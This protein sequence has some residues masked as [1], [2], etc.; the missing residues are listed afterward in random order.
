MF[1]GAAIP[2]CILVMRKCRKQKEDILFIDASQQFEKVKTTNVMRAE[3]IAKIVEVYKARVA[4]EKFS[5]LVSINEIKE[6]GWSLN[7]PKYVVRFEAEVEIDLNDLSTKLVMLDREAAEVDKKI[8][9]FCEELGI[10]PPFT[11]DNKS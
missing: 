4:E 9:M 2:T 6:N 10:K 3:H 7:I 11:A 8:A 1:Y 5:A